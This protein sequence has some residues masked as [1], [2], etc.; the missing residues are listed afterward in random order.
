M[1]LSKLKTEMGVKTKV[2]TNIIDNFFSLLMHSVALSLSLL[3]KEKSLY[4]LRRICDYFSE[5]WLHIKCTI[6][7]Q[8]FPAVLVWFEVIVNN[9][10][11]F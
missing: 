4:F 7:M 3:H 8:G 6:S 2:P 10:K 5:H 9:W 11:T 1:L